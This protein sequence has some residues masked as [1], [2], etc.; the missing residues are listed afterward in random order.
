MM[1]TKSIKTTL[2]ALF[3]LAVAALAPACDIFNPN[4]C[5]PSQEVCPVTGH[6]DMLNPG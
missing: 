4:P 6:P 1:N 5:D 3:L 2:S